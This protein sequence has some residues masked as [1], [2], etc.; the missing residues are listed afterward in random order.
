MS[1]LEFFA[2]PLVKF[3]PSNRD[4]RSYYNQFVEYGGW[5]RCPVRF[6]CPEEHGL[7]L[8]SMIQRQMLEYYL[9]KEFNSGRIRPKP[10][11]VKTVRK[12][13]QK[14]KKLVDNKKN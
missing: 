8:P 7:D 12:D 4:H 3:D 9:K 10:L 14:A 2:R 13:V 6:I 5:G 11:P 1:R